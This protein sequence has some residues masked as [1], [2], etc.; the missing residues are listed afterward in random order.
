[1]IRIFIY[2]KFT[3]NVNIISHPNK[4]AYEMFKRRRNEITALSEKY[5]CWSM[6]TKTYA[7]KEKNKMIFTKSTFQCNTMNIIIWIWYI[8]MYTSLYGVWCTQ[9]QKS[10]IFVSFLFM[11]IFIIYFFFLIFGLLVCGITLASNT[12]HTYRTNKCKWTVYIERVYW[13][14]CGA[15]LFFSKILL[16]QK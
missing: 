3:L 9:T 1:M 10:N 2:R 6:H 13:C 14:F 5:P 7:R 12:L 16:P 15:N 8:I 11:W 4:C